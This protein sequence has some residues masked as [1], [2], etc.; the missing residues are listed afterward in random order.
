MGLPPVLDARPG[1]ELGS[2]P[3]PLALLLHLGLE[4]GQID[5]HA[6]LARDVRG[7]IDGEA[8]GVVELEHRRAVEHAVLA[9]Q[10]AF[11]HLHAVL[12]GLGEALFLLLEHA[13]HAA[14]LAHAAP[15]RPRPSRGEIVDQQVEEGLLLAELVAVADGAADDPAQH[16]AAAFVARNHAVDDQEAAGA[17]VVGDDLQRVAGRDPSRRSRARRLGSGPGTGRSRSCCARPAGPRRCAPAPCRCRPTAWAADARCPASSRLN[18]M[19]TR[20]QISM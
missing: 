11:Q 14:L 12:E 5:L 4:T 7:Q 9:V 2:G 20:F 17:D 18:C 13:D 3:R 19:N 16:V 15:D 8:E 1:L 6:A 10:R